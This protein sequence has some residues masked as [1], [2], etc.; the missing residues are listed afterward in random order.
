MCDEDHDPLARALGYRAYQQ[1]DASR[2]HPL[3]V[4]D[5]HQDRP[6]ARGSGENINNYLKC[7]LALKGRTE[8]RGFVFRAGRYRKNRSVVAKRMRN[9]GDSSYQKRA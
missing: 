6:L 2:I 8:I 7:P 5:N 1:F 3:D 4:L 9:I